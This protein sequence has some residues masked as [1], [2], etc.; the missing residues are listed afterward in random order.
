MSDTFIGLTIVAVGTSL[1][2]L[3]TSIVAAKK[4]ESDLALGNVVGSNIFN[5]IFILGFSAVIA[6]MTVDIASIYDMIVLIG[7]SVVGWIFAK[8]KKTVSRIEGAVM[9]GIYAIYFVY[10][11]LR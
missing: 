8:T 7:I 11:L 6:P 3:V 4:G 9:L 5:I 2:E 1:P 10:I